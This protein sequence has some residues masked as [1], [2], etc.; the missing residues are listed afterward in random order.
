MSYYRECP[1]CGD[2]LDP[3]ERCDCKDERRITRASDKVFAEI[4]NADGQNYE[5]LRLDAAVRE[6]DACI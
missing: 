4:G 6:A 5:Q 3:G 1:Q 2:A